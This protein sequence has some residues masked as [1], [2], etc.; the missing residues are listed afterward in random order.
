MKMNNLKK[1]FAIVILFHSVVFSQNVDNEDLK[2]MVLKDQEIRKDNTTNYEL[3]DKNHRK[4]V[5]ELLS[6]GKIITAND[7]LNAAL[8]LQH[9]ALNYCD[10]NLK[11]ESVENYYLAY[12]LSKSAFDDG[13]TAAGPFVATTYDRY[14]LYTIGYQKYGTQRLYDEE[15]DREYLAPIDPNTTDEERIQ[16]QIPTL[17]ELQ[18]KYP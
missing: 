8:I 13:V 17:K 2:L 14:L 10:N 3:I 5:F 12:C 4:K 9:T 15:K 1:I 18:A 11:S 16:L 6:Y 7:K